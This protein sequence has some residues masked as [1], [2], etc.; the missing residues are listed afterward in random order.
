MKAASGSDGGT[1]IRGRDH[2]A[3]VSVRVSDTSC[4]SQNTLLLQTTGVQCVSCDLR[5]A[6]MMR[7]LFGLDL[8]LQKVV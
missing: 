7:A 6:L 2:H 5:H 1:V 8:N 3:L 4:T